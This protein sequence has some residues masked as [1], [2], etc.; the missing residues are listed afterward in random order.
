MSEAKQAGSDVPSRAD[1]ATDADGAAG[2][3]DV[4]AEARDDAAKARNLEARGTDAQEAALNRALAVRDRAAAANARGEAAARNRAAADRSAAQERDDTADKSADHHWL[5]AQDR[6]ADADDRHAAAARADAAT[7]RDHAAQARESR[8]AVSRATQDH[9]TRDDAAH[10]RMASATDRLRAAG[11]RAAS[12]QDLANA[13]RDEMTGTLLRDAGRDQ[14]RQTAARVR[15]SGESLVLAFIDVDGLK[16]VNDRDGHAAGDVV[17]AAV[18]RELLAN[19][20]T[21]DVVVR[22][23]GDEF[24]CGLA[25]CTLADAEMRF[26]AL[27][28]ALEQITT[29]SVGLTLLEADED[30][31]QA[32]GRA[33]RCMYDGRRQRRQ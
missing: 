9:T 2:D 14:L 4:A 26:T 8:S 5:D 20:R 11:D 28:A 18:G 21:Y 7:D 29:I 19:V 6:I 23:G 10:D 16:Q 22:W 3:R 32:I 31:N 25:G 30:L 24:V 1:Q 27:A 17:L 33:D 12:E 15:R 13:Y